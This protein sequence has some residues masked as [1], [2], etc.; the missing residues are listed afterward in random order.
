VPLFYISLRGEKKPK[1]PNSENTTSPISKM[2]KCVKKNMHLRIGNIIYLPHLP[3]D[4]IFSELL[5]VH[6]LFNYPQDR[7]LFISFPYRLYG[8]QP[9]CISYPSATVK[10]ESMG[11]FLRLPI[12]MISSPTI[13]K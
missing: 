11:V 2:L 5:S 9:V 13:F 8:P 6:A 1:T 10:R 12:I 3:S 4:D 7:S